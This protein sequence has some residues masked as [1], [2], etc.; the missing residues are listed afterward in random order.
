[1]KK[2]LFLLLSFWL[3][4]FNSCSKNELKDIIN[5][6][7]LPEFEG[8]VLM[9]NAV[10]S[11]S[12]QAS[13]VSNGY[14][15]PLESG[16]CWS[17]VN[18]LPTVA[19]KIINLPFNDLSLSKTFAWNYSTKLY[20]RAY[21]K[22]SVG[23]S[24]SEPLLVNW[25]GGPENMPVVS[26]DSIVSI[27]FT[28]FKIRGELI[29][30]GGLPIIE[31]GFCYSPVNTN[32]T[33]ANSI[34]LSLDSEFNVTATG[35]NDS[36]RYYVRPF[37]RNIQGIGYGP[38]LEITTRNILELGE[39][40]PAGGLIFYRYEDSNNEW[41]YYEAAPFDAFTPFK[42]S[43]DAQSVNQT[44]TAINWGIT[45]TTNIVSAYG[46]TGSYAALAAQ[47]FVYGG[48][49][50]WYLPSRDELMQ[51]RQNLFLN[52]TGNISNNAYYWSSS[53]D[54]TFNTNAWVVNMISS[55]NGNTV[56]LIKSSEL[57]VRFVRRF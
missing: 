2:A 42:W 48:Y 46:P 20:I 38:V 3:L 27:S 7:K 17:D 14:D 51:L 4:L 23:M 33:T 29:S 41:K 56:S 45:N 13:L 52:G 21:C 19:D 54:Q 11:F 49:S 57:K 30:D 43:P 16:F 50:D 10:D 44:S 15:T 39:T 28:S 53:Q 47:S 32:P 6:D 55:A 22:N 35:L 8:I 1:M 40:G 36:T 26:T 24:Y 18:N 31:K 12:V 25:S 34:K 5:L 9:S 37:A